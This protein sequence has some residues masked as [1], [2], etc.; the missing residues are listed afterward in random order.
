MPTIPHSA[1]GWRIEP[2]V[3]VPIDSGAW[4]AATAAAEPAAAPARH[5][6]ERPRVGGRAVGRVLGRRAHRELVHVGLAED[7]R[8]GVA[9]A[10]RD[11]RVVRG[12]VALED[13][14]AGGALAALDRHEVLERRPGRRAAGGA[15]RARRRR[16]R[17][18]SSSRA[19]AASASASAR[20]RSMVSQALSAPLSALGRVEVRRGQLAR[21]DLAGA[22][23][24]GQLVGEEPGRIG[25]SSGG[26]SPPRIAGTT[27][28]SPSRSAALAEDRLDG[29]RRRH[30]VVAQ[31]VLELDRLGRR[32]RCGRSGPSARIAYW[33]RMW[34][35]CPS[36][37]VSSSSV[38]PS[39]ARWATC[40]TSARDRVAMRPMI[41]RRRSDDAA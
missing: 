9:Q 10:L 26:Q 21:R 30:H 29:Q 27:M 7:H 3:S 31:D 39:R 33:S 15:R 34:L 25:R 16:R 11:V 13:A 32:A 23:P 35:S 19:S 2:P 28:R 41:A 40:S 1:A 12:E 4:Y 37:R 14:R 18:R 24:R 6:V 38:S 17:G 5:A 22:Q 36:S 8:A 20:S